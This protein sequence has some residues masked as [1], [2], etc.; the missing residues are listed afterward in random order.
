MF[1]KALFFSLVSII[2]FASAQ[3][4]VHTGVTT[5]TGYH[6]GWGQAMVRVT[7]QGGIY[8]EFAACT[9]H[10]GYVVMP[11][12]SYDNGYET[13]I[14]ALLAAY[15]A[16]KKVQLVLSGCALNRPRIIGVSVFP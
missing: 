15:M 3:Q 16:G 12:T 7:L 8:N 2:P 1:R 11:E 4:V 5:I 14:S 6:T 13:H 10:D 9:E